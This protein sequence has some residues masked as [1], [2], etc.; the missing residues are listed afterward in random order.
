MKII[1][2]AETTPALLAGAKTVTRREW[3][4]KHARSFKAG[5]LVQAWSKGPRVKGAKRI[6]TVR[7]TGAPY[8]EW[9]C[10]AGDEDYDAEGFTYLAERGLTLFG[11]VTPRDLWAHWQANQVPLW[12]V[13]FEL[14]EVL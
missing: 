8:L 9:S 2:F 4:E 11:G 13:R 6:G 3:T 1:S 14:V 5:E 7:L 10:E 12:V